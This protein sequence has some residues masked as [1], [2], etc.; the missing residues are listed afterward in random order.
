MEESTI[1]VSSILS[2]CEKKIAEILSLDEF[3]RKNPI[4]HTGPTV[5]HELKSWSQLYKKTT[6]IQV[7]Y[8]F[9]EH[10]R[11]EFHSWLATFVVIGTT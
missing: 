7:T 6:H 10:P 5:R 9:T 11:L 3:P 8:I 2:C 1:P 4:E